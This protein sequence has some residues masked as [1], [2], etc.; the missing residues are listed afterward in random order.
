MVVAPLAVAD[1]PWTANGMAAINPRD[2]AATDLATI[3]TLVDIACCGLAVPAAF[4]AAP[5]AAATVM[6]VGGGPT[7]ATATA[8][9]DGRRLSFL[10]T[11]T[12]VGCGCAACAERAVRMSDEGRRRSA[13]GSS[14]G[15]AGVPR[16]GGPGAAAARK[17]AAADGKAPQTNDRSD[18]G[19]N[20][21][22]KMAEHYH[23]LL[24]R[25][26]PL[27]AVVRAGRRV[28]VA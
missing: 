15:A 3:S 8:A 21:K 12:S 24:Q 2:S 17:V 27:A 14:A 25:I 9:D 1:L 5:A 18:T 13:S 22:T 19:A 10:P 6:G 20:L 11:T 28:K 23:R 4:A 16:Q 7:A 26:R